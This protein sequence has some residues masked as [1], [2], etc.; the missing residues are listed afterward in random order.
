MKINKIIAGMVGLAVIASSCTVNEL[1]N[2]TELPEG[3]SVRLNFSSDPAAPP[4]SDATRASWED[5]KGS[6]NLTFKWEKVDIDSEEADE[7]VLI[8]TD[9]E[10]PVSVKVTSNEEPASYSGLS[11]TPRE[12]D[13]HFANFQTVGYYSTDDLK[14]AKYCFA[15]TGA[16]VVT[17][18]TGNGR[19]ICEL[20][21]MPSTFVQPTSQDPSFLRDYMYMYSTAAY[22]GNGSTLSFKHIP[23]TFRFI[24]SNATD[25]PVQVDEIH[26]KTASGGPIASKSSAV[27]FDWS[28]GTA[29]LS[30]GED[31]YD[32]VSVSPDAG[33]TVAAG[34]RYTAYAMSSRWRTTTPSKA[35]L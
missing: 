4:Q 12:S 24:I 31:A 26:I 30:F 35:R 19:H 11:V 1:T 16:P 5:P 7:Q 14:K 15:V 33:A 3:T 18:D 13:A 25:E 32:M 8:I 6:G 28:D 9:G 2:E 21:D 10:K 34:E 20:P 23:A 29:S 17:E 27:T 22:S